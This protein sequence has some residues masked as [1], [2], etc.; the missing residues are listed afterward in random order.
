MRFVGFFSV[1]EDAQSGIVILT[2]V[3]KDVVRKT[4]A[5]TSV[6]PLGGGGKTLV[7]LS[8]LHSPIAISHNKETKKYCSVPCGIRRAPTMAGATF[9]SVADIDQNQRPFSSGI[10]T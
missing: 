4:T 10:K 9:I 6:G 5:S 1:R 2:T 8:P 3:A 7:S